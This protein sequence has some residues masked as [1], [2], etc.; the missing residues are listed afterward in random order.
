MAA[1]AKY[2]NLKFVL[3]MILDFFL[4]EEITVVHEN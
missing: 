4:L 1:L 3:T 2:I